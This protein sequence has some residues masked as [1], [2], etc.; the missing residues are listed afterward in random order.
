MQDLSDK[1]ILDR[2]NHIFGKQKKNSLILRGESLSNRIKRLKSLKRWIDSNDK[3]IQ[4]AIFDDFKKPAGAVDIS[5]IYP[6]LTELKDAIANLKRWAK[7]TKVDTSV[8]Y[9][10]TTASVKYEPK[11]VCLIISPWNFPF[12]LTLGPL[13]SALAAGNTVIIKPSEMTPHTSDIMDKMIGD[14]YREDYVA[15]FKGDA[16]MSQMLLKLPF[17]H[18]FFT[19]SPH[20]G[21]VV[22]RAAA[23]HLTS[24]TLELGGKSPTVVDETAN[25]R[26]A[27]QKIAWGK[28]MNNGQTC[29]APD[30]ILVHESV[31]DQFL[32][33]LKKYVSKLFDTGNQGFKQS[34]DYARVVN[35]RHLTRLLEL[36]D[37]AVSSGARL[38]I[39]KEVDE[40]D[41]FLSPVI[42]TR[43][44]F[45]TRVMQE[46]VFGPV[47]PVLTF[48]SLNEVITRV[49]EQPK[50]LAFY[51]FGRSRKTRKKLLSETS[52]GTFCINDCVLQFGHPHLPFGGVNNS[53][54]G[55]SHGKYGFLAFS[56]EKAVLRQRVG[57]TTTKLVYPPYGKRTQLIS[58]LLKKYF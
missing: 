51:Y 19:G 56:N 7:A 23:E 14:L 34:E 3:M 29:V 38:A 18:I 53:G 50:P 4:K 47:L 16:A 13:I 41:C 8:A 33:E 44:S 27:A 24:I 58:K 10:S 35:Q 5:E 31:Q 37:D 20:V 42:L 6:V 28:F 12:L 15:V 30:Y 46:E 48:S 25:I 32:S 9:L 40:E 57:L 17:D 55:K 36:V 39:P 2:V 26:D 54:I 11:G 21:K 22:M 52:S 1:T 43:V 49:N 45:N